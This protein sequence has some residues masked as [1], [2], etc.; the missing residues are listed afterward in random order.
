[1]RASNGVIVITT[2]KGT[3]AGKPAFNY[4]YN[5]FFDQKPDLDRMQLA[6][7]ADIVDYQND[8]IDTWALI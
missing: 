7:S 8:F 3:T 2:R 6:S 1:M 5:A 4:S